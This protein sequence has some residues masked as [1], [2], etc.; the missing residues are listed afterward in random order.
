[1]ISKLH[2]SLVAA[3]HESLFSIFNEKYHA[4][5]VIER[6]LRAHKKWGARDR[7]FYV[8]A[9]YEIVRFWRRYLFALSQDSYD[10]WIETAL[11]VDES[12]I[13][14][15]FALWFLEKKDWD[16]QWAEQIPWTEEQ[17]FSIQKNWKELFEIFS[18]KESV[19]QGFYEFF[20][21]QVG[22]GRAHKILASLNAQ[23]PLDIRV[24]SLKIR[25]E[26]LKEIFQDKGME[27]REVSHCS[28]ALRLEKTSIFRTE[29]FQ[30]GFFEVQDAGSQRIAP[31]LQVEPG[32]RVVDACAGSGGKSLH[33]GALM[34]NKGRIISMDIV[35]YK[36]SELRRRSS[37]AGI[38]IIETRLI[39]TSKDI[40]KLKGTAD[41]LLLDVPCS[42]TGV[43]RRH[44][45][46][47]WWLTKEILFRIHEQQ[48][49]ILDRY[50]SMLRPGG[51]MVYATCSLLPMENSE[52]VKEFLK[53][54]PG[55]LEEE[56]YLDP[57]E[58][59]D[60]FYAARISLDK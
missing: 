32:Q 38:D 27:V 23:A 5:K 50:S 15:V 52:V 54:H 57:T 48:K 14:N 9:V 13:E 34:E 1:M 60:G 2:P 35:D 21:T 18:V 3:V 24:N 17:F 31:F 25:K 39:E 7:N 16:P 45:E 6:T 46:G 53:T 56:L 8:T 40:K 58:D 12:L 36:L 42:G 29:E 55:T 22:E 59:S 11:E 41:R 4:P 10:P 19:P 26:E 44:P 47:K 33:L 20:K 43:W 51:K 37:R 49:D 28:S 30:Q